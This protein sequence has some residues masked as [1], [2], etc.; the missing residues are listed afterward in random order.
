MK[1]KKVSSIIQLRDKLNDN[2]VFANE[3]FA[4]MGFLRIK[5]TDY[6]SNDFPG[7]VRAKFSDIEGKLH[8]I[9]EKVPVISEQDWDEHTAYPFWTLVPGHILER[10]VE[11]SITKTGKEIKTKIVKISLEKPWGIYDTNDETIFEVFDGDIV[12]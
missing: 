3:Q 7:F 1:K 8:T 9:E 11:I 10:H 5:V 12:G 6:I 4:K 2:H